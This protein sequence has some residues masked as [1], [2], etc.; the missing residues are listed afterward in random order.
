[1]TSGPLNRADFEALWRDVTDESYWRPFVESENS[2]IEAI[3][4]AIEQSQRASVVVDRTTQSMYIFPW[5]GQSDEPASGEATAVVELTISRTMQIDRLIVLHAGLIIPHITTDSGKDGAVSVETGRLYILAESVVFMPGDA[6]PHTAIAIAERPG[7]G[8]NNPLPGTLTRLRQAFSSEITNSA[9]ATGVSTQIVVANSTGSQLS[10][11]H[12]YGYLQFTAGSLEGQIRQ[13]R[14]YVGTDIPIVELDRY[15]RFTGTVTG[16]FRVGESVQ[17]L[18]DGDVSAFGT[19]LGIDSN[20][21]VIDAAIG[22]QFTLAGG[23]I[24]GTTSGATFTPA[25]LQQDYSVSGSSYWRFVNWETDL[26]VVITNASAPTG[27]RAAMLDELG[28]ERNIYRTSGESDASYRT[29]VGNP[30]DLISPNAIRRTANH[31]LQPYGVGCCFRQVGSR[32]LPGMFFDA[33]SSASPVQNPAVNFAFD[34]PTA[35]A[36]QNRNKV[37]LDMIHF[38]GWFK[39]GIPPLKLGRFGCAFDLYPKNAMDVRL[40]SANFFDGYDAG[41][42]VV[43]AAIW[44]A[45]ERARAFG[46]RWD[47]YIESVGCF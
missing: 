14:S 45:V 1:M 27:G 8:Y 23:A 22:S 40:P 4:Q 36:P 33:G 7:T 17:Q 41:N 15:Q 46:V 31:I 19:L 10:P 25:V 43:Y 5:S 16:T 2:P 21:I 34:M 18:T 37:M 39:L 9:T 47:L 6:G 30:A 20:Q 29:R 26:G 35:L 42:R 24:Y 11:A 38:R 32:L 44:A 28:I 3:D 12:L 13:I